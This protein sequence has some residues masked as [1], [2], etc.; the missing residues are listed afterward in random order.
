[1]AHV[2]EGV[3]GTAQSEDLDIENFIDYVNWA[4]LF[5]TS[6]FLSDIIILGIK[7]DSVIWNM[8]VPGMESVLDEYW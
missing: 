2:V 8:T 3:G 5:N 4:V 1:M 7:S 6:A